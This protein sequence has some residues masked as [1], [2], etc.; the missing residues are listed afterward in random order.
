MAMQILTALL[1]T[2]VSGMLSYGAR[3]QPIGLLISGATPFEG[4]RFSHSNNAS[5]PIRPNASDKEYSY[6]IRMN[7]SSADPT[8]IVNP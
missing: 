3:I 5:G 6:T 4:Q 1:S 7:G 2:R 8:I